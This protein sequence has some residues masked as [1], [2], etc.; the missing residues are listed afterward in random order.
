[1]LGDEAQ[2]KVYQTLEGKETAKRQGNA[3]KEYYKT[4]TAWNKGL[5]WPAGVKEHTRATI[6]S[7]DK[8]S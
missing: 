4:H 2:L 8:A 3:L 7:H 5:R 6:F 1:M